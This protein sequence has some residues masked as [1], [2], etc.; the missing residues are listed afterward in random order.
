MSTLDQ[1]QA[2]VAAVEEG[3]F[4]AA[5]LLFDVS[6]AALGK[7][8]AALEKSLDTKLLIRTP[9]LLMMTD[10][11]KKYYEQCKKVLQEYKLS[12]LLVENEKNEI[13]GV[14][15]IVC[16][17]QIAQQRI[18]PTMAGFLELYPHIITN[19]TVKKSATDILLN[20]FD[21]AIGYPCTEVFND[22]RYGRLDSDY[23]Y[24]PNLM[25]MPV[26]VEVY[27][28]HLRTIQYPR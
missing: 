18:Y 22:W 23:F 6:P 17:R 21:L 9:R 12:T 5:A 1:M 3:S 7:K 20:N 11:G 4:T 14:L 16:T 25:P 13:Q 19:V 10:I 26:K 2:Y 15:N 24:H 28:N 27:L 8:I